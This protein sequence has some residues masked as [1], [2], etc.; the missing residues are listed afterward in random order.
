[1]RNLQFYVSG[2]RP[3]FAV[4]F[5]FLSQVPSIYCLPHCLWSPQ[6]AVVIVVSAAV[7]VSVVVMR[8]SY[9]FYP[10]PVWASGCCR[11][12]CDCLCVRPSVRTYVRSS[13][14]PSG[15]QPPASPRHVKW[16]YCHVYIHDYTQFNKHAP[17]IWYDNESWREH[18]L[19]VPQ[20]LRFW[21]SY[22]LRWCRRRKIT[23]YAR[24]WIKLCGIVQMW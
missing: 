11:I 1:M 10:R 4:W 20:F 13:V 24:Q 23:Y 15:R 3:V 8:P 12:A 9:D 5:F 6:R 16:V 17:N 22:I 18:R 19:L 14:R 21:Q 7:V 2:K